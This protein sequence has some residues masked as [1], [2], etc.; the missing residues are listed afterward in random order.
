MGRE[1]LK[2]LK[3]FI[4][5]IMYSGEKSALKSAK[6]KDKIKQ[7]RNTTEGAMGKSSL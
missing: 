2:N 5:E 3:H 7:Y 1:T 6:K 4:V